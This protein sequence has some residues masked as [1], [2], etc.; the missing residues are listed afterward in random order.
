MAGAVAGAAGATVIAQDLLPVQLALYVFAN[1][2]L[3]ALG[4]YLAGMARIATLLEAPGRALWR[5]I[6]PL[7]SRLGPVNTPARAFIA[8]LMWGWLPCGLTYG[9]LALALLSGSA[10]GG[11]EVMAVFGIGTLPGLLLAGSLL[12]RA[13]HWLRRPLP[14]RI[15]GVVILATGLAGMAQA[16]DIASQLRRG[17]LCL[18]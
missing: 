11:A 14:R 10:V 4:A 15:A 1:L 12:H 6:S 13:G 18:G 2:I 16:A 5:H 7:S 17:L 8:G 9:V 3:L